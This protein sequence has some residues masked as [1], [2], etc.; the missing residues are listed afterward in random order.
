[1]QWTFKINWKWIAIFSTT[2]LIVVVVMLANGASYR[3]VVTVLALMVTMPFFIAGSAIW[4]VLPVVAV[5]KY[6]KKKK[7]NK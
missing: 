6:F 1:M 3:D 2:A 7:D 5:Y 4:I